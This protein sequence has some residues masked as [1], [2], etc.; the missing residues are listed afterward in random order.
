MTMIENKHF[1]CAKIVRCKVMTIK[2]QKGYRWYE[3]HWGLLDGVGR[4]LEGIRGKGVSGVYW[5][6]AGSVGTQGTE[7]E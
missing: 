3:G 4:L 1:N 7:G 5:G 6:L 2:T